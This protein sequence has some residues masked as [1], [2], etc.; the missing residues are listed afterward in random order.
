[1]VIVTSISSTARAEFYV[2]AL[3]VMAA[4]PHRMMNVAA[5]MSAP[6]LSYLPMNLKP[7][8]VGCGDEGT[9]SFAIDAVRKL[10]TSYGSLLRFMGSIRAKNWRLRSLPQAG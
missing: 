10:T 3:T 9:A 7:G 4:T 2:P 5:A 8:G 1:V 6:P